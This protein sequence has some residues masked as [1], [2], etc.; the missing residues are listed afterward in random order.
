MLESYQHLMLKRLIFT[1][2][3]V[4]TRSCHVEGTTSTYQVGDIP[5][6]AS[7]CQSTSSLVQGT[8][9]TQPYIDVQNVDGME[10]IITPS[11][12]RFRRQKNLIDIDTNILKSMH[13]KISMRTCQ[14]KINNM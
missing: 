7:Y 1:F 12:I 14:R 4:H 9:S 6:F 11:R 10:E 2:D 13:E 8:Q 3:D 5:S